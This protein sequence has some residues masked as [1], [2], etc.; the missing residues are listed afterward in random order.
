MI[1]KF[2]S[3]LHLQLADS[4]LHTETEKDLKHSCTHASHQCLLLSRMLADLF[5]LLFLAIDLDL[6]WVTGRHSAAPDPILVAFS[7]E[8]LKKNDWHKSKIELNNARLLTAG[9]NLFAH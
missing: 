8:C 3:Q 9:E 2:S 6:Q 4:R 5:H 7:P 1:Y